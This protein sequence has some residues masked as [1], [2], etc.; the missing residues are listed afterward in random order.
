MQMSK[1]RIYELAKELNIDS[2]QIID[3]LSKNGIKAGNHM[4]SIDE[5]GINLVKASMKG[6]SAQASCPAQPEKKAEQPSSL[7]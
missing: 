4:S 3:V 1:K 6:A 2:K 7:N 5:S